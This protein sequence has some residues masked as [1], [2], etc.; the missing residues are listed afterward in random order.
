MNKVILVGNLTR[1]VSVFK[2]EKNTILRFTVALENGYDADGNEKTGY[3]D[4]T[5]IVKNDSKLADYLVKGT[6]VAVDGR[7]SF[8]TYVNKLGIKVYNTEV[9]VSALELLSSKKVAEEPETESKEPKE[10]K[11]V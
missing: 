7:L 11:E 9:L 1:D 4:C 3:I 10:A 8:N 6:K 2:T 5:N